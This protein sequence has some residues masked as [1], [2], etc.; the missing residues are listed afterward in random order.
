MA[1][2][3]QT[4]PPAHDPYAAMRFY[5]FRLLIFGRLIAQIGEMT[6]SV[7][8]GWELYERTGDALALGLVGLVQV[9]PV[10]LLSLPGG[11]VADRYDRKK[12][13]LISQIVLVLCSLA[14]TFLSTNN[15]SL[16]LIY[17]TLAIIGAARAFNNPAESAL[18]PQTVPPEHYFSAA[19]W[20]STVWQLSAIL[21]P[22]VG[23]LI[24]GITN[25]AAPVYFLNAAA[26]ITFV[27]ALMIL[28]V[29]YKGDVG[30]NEPPIKALK[31]GWRFLLDSPVILGAITLDMFA[32]LLGGVTFLLPVFAKD[33]LHVDAL[34]LGILR[35]GQSIG[36]L[37]MAF[38]ITRRPPFEQ[39][40]KTMLW[41]VAGFGVATIIFGFSTSFWLSLAM[42]ILM[43]ALDN[44]SVVVRHSLLMIFTPD[45]MRG[46]VNSVNTI[47]IGASNELG[48]FESGVLAAFLGP[49]AAV[50]LGGFGTL[51][52]V[53]I[54][55]QYI[56]RLRQLGR[57]VEQT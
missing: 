30:V 33:I 54:V 7:A 42:L 24:I 15:G 34:G 43:G 49:V 38:A 51:A 11:Y 4:T 40:G 23:G 41:S 46:R 21:G 39:A 57:L 56:P 10:I 47:F 22:A 36:A 50:I 32:V 45:E 20:S 37:A 53:G 52:V 19:T 5:D 9:I 26:G 55:A 28:K 25:S 14:L 1:E 13:V 44:I 48:G 12:A 3:I 2:Q 17:F 6:V 31:Q 18:T 8:I 16:P 35:T 29:K 27:I